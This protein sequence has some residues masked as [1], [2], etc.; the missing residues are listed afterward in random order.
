MVSC[1]RAKLTIYYRW[2]YR[3]I[4][5]WLD[6]EREG[7]RK[8]YKRDAGQEEILGIYLKPKTVPKKLVL[9]LAA[10]GT[11]KTTTIV[12]LLLELINLGSRSPIQNFMVLTFTKRTRNDILKKF[13]DE[14]RRDLI[15]RLGRI[16]RNFHSLA[17]TSLF[18][19]DI[20][21]DTDIS[22]HIKEVAE[23]AGMNL[24][25]PDCMKVR[26]I[27]KLLKEAIS[28]DRIDDTIR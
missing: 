28:Q 21:T 9:C 10:P 1:E 17:F 25:G 24:E 5:I 26:K 12:R 20:L 11:G 16:V 18:W 27:I 6:M 3:I 7:G 14:G 8:K 23:S 13:E 15:N 22:N 2:Y 19:E 4:T